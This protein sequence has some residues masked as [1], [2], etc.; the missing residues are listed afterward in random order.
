MTAVRTALVIGG[1]IAGPATAM[2]LVKAGID[3]RVYEARPDGSDDAGVMITLAANGIDALR[4]LGADGPALA[5]GFPT[6]G[7]T[8]L[9]HTGKRLGVATSGGHLPDGTVSHTM[10]RADLYRALQEQAVARGITVRR[11]RR[12]RTAREHPSGVQAVFDDGSTA[13]ADVLIGCD[14]IYST[15]RRLIDP[16]APAP[17]YSGLLTTGG[18]ADGVTVPAPAGGYEM[19]FGKQA[20]FGYTLAP[21]GQVWWFVNI[22]RA[23]EP[24]R[25]ELAGISTAQW[26]ACFAGLYAEDAGPALEII[27]G[28]PEFASPWPIHTMPRLPR[29]HRGR[30]IVIGDAAHAPS[31]T[32]GQGASLS[33]EDAVVVATCLRDQNTPD[34]AFAAFE[35]AR[36]ARVEKI[37]KAAARMNSAKAPGPA[38]RF[39]RDLVLPAVLRAT[40]NAKS[41][42]QVYEH[43]VDWDAAAGSQS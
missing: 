31:P 34:A 4:T 18:Y 15:V 17:R 37:V 9:N 32:S 23:R 40:A 10:R 39:M 6:P 35:R 28:T 22:P 33:I 20:F 24:G 26:R 3:A 43:H 27:T 7:I 11:G 42:R 38:G 2:A 41:A 5:A 1:G 36:R 12:L 16:A 30:M 21:G 19:I 13:E 8:L 25:G 29:W 14:G